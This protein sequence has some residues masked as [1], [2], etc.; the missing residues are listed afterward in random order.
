MR[1]VLPYRAAQGVQ[2]Q[3]FR[4]AGGEVHLQP[5]FMLEEVRCS[6]VG[7]DNP[8]TVAPEDRLNWEAHSD[9]YTSFDMMAKL[10]GAGIVMDLY[11]ARQSA[12]GP[13]ES[14]E[15]LKKR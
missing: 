6:I 9:G 5:A 2:N 12:V 7:V 15:T 1:K 13:K 11:R 4:Y 3:Q 14:A 8:Q 10:Q